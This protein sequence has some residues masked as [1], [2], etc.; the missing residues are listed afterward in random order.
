MS[1]YFIGKKLGM[2][3]VFQENGEVVPVTVI[4]AGPCQVVQ[5]KTEEHDRYNAIQLGFMDKKEKNVTKPLLGHFKKAGVSPKR[6]LK[7]S[8][9]ENVSDYAVGQE[10]KVDVFEKGDYVDVIGITKGKGF[11][12]VVKRW[13]F[14]GGKASHGS[15]AHRI[16]GSI[17]ASAT[18]SRVF[19]GQKL[20]GHM[21]H[22]ACTMQ[23]LQV[24]DVR[25]DDNQLLIRGAVPGATNS[26]VYIR[27]AKK[28]SSKK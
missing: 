28:K 17:G 14:K 5:V 16:P 22:A 15:R 3:Q 26:I 18:P 10:V 6:H 7:E 8:R 23:N 12:G 20:P 19:K 9:I 27:K 2:T 24:V 13:G 4:E 21:G 11:A 1:L 25:A